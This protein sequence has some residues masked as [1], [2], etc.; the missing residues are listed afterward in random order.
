MEAALDCPL[1]ESA[2]PNERNRR[3]II[4]AK[5]Y[6]LMLFKLDSVCVNLVHRPVSA[7]KLLSMGIRRCNQLVKVGPDIFC[8]SVSLT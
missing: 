7:D 1:Q 3:Q 6:L 4:E 2:D 8:K 5:A